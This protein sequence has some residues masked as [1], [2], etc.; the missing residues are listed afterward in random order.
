VLSTPP[1]KAIRT[2][3]ISRNEFVSVSNLFGTAK[4]A[5]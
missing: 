3:F 5:P 2:R 1:E 4:N